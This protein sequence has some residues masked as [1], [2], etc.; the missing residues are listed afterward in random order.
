M[1]FLSITDIKQSQ[2]KVVIECDEWYDDGIFA[3]KIYDPFG[4]KVF[5][6]H[7]KDSDSDKCWTFKDFINEAVKRFNKSQK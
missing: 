5:E 1:R 7:V 2:Q 3:I 4:R 6:W